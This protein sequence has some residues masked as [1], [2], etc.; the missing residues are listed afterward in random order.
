[1]PHGSSA[2]SVAMTMD[3]TSPV[4]PYG[5]KLARAK[6]VNAQQADSRMGTAN[7]T[8]RKQ[9]L[10]DVAIVALKP[11]AHER[12]GEEEAEA[13]LRD[14]SQARRAPADRAHHGAVVAAD[15]RER[16]DCQEELDRHQGHDEQRRRVLEPQDV[17]PPVEQHDA[18]SSQLMKVVTPST[19]VKSS[20]AATYQCV[21]KVR[22]KPKGSPNRPTVYTSMPAACSTHAIHVDEYHAAGIEKKS[23]SSSS[24]GQSESA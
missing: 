22:S 13:V 9:P 11:P 3:V 7:H 17:A 15:D 12:R 8:S 20:V 6:S 18:Y 2:A 5:M 21:K 1:M 4:V 10:G 24:A 23:S 14:P 19:S 16:G